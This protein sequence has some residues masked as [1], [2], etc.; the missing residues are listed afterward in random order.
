MHMTSERWDHTKAY[1]QDVFGRQDDHLASLM[2]RA[3]EAG[4]P[5]IAIT[6]DVG[7]FIHLMA[8][9]T[10]ATLAVEL[11]TLA[12]YSTIWLARAVDRV[13]TIEREPA[14]AA[15]ARRMFEEAGVADRVEIR[16]GDAR[17]RLAEV[18]REV[19]E[20]DVLFLDASKR[21]Y[22]EYLAIARDHIAPGGLILAD[23]A[24][25]GDWWID[26]APGNPDRD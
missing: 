21:E 13:I 15:F 9:T 6:A 20:I 14:H 26:D 17:E 8:K 10:R 23:N 12:G 7:R 4:L 11:G 3:R 1:L 22:P 18:V 25:G 16:Q 19:G 2:D 5:D 24:L